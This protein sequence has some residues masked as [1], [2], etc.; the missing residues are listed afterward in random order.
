LGEPAGIIAASRADLDL[1]RGGRP[2]PFN[3]GALGRATDIQSEGCAVRGG[4]RRARPVVGVGWESIRAQGEG[5]SRAERIAACP[6][7]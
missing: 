2:A 5:G 7:G 6:T 1:I 3:G 4:A